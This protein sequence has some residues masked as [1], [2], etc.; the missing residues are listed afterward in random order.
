MSAC[1]QTR[2]SRWKSELC[3][4]AGQVSEGHTTKA[5]S[6]Q[7]EEFGYYGLGNGVSLIVSGRGEE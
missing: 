6:C 5:L 2:N 7:T 4:D 1:S 3:D